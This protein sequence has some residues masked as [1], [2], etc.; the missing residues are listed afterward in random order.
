MISLDRQQE[1]SG[2]VEIERDFQKYLKRDIGYISR[3][4]LH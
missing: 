2:W 4:L 3:F 1:L